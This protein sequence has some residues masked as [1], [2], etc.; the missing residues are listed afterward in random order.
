MERKGAVTFQGNPLTLLGEEVKV[1]QKAPG[2]TVLDSDLQEVGL[3]AFTG[4]I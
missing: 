2:F 4:K 1:G 3:D